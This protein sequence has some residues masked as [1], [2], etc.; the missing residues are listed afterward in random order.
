MLEDTLWAEPYFSL[1]HKDSETDVQ[2]QE[3]L[4]S[5][6]QFTKI[7]IFLPSA[8]VKSI[9]LFHV[10]GYVILQCITVAVIKLVNYMQTYF[11]YF[12]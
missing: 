5:L 11:S 4:R 7:T 2:T 10:Y 1:S 9:C 3:M 12:I 8:L 6:M